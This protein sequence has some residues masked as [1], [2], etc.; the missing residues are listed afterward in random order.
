MPGGPGSVLTCL[1]V[2]ECTLFSLGD[3]ISPS[4]LKMHELDV[5]VLHVVIGSWQW[6]H[7]LAFTHLRAWSVSL[8]LHGRVGD[9]QA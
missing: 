4:G 2:R 1:A 3:G 8:Q 5:L 9:G 6:L 7:G